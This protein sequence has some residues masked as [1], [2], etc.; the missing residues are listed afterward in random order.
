[1]M[2]EVHT[3]QT[4]FYRWALGFPLLHFFEKYEQIYRQATKLPVPTT[5]AL[6]STLEIEEIEKE[7]ESKGVVVFPVID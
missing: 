3:E 7:K 4:I 1:M 2:I 5:T 6:S